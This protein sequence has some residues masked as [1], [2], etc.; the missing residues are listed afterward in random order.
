MEEG[1]VKDIPRQISL[2][3]NN[4]QYLDKTNQVQ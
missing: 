1:S 3:E 4:H 2:L